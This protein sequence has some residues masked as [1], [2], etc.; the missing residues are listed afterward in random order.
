MIVD[1][2]KKAQHTSA[3]YDVCI[4]GSGPAGVTVAN[5]L[6]GTGLK[7]CVLESGTL[8]RKEYADKLRNVI[9]EGINIKDC[10]RERIIGGASSTW[11]GLSS[12]FDPIDFKKR[13]WVSGSGWPFSY[14][15]LLKYYDRASD[16]YNFPCVSSFSSSGSKKKNLEGLRLRWESIKEKI[17]IATIKPQRFGA[18]FLDIFTDGDIDLF[19]N[20]TVKILKKEKRQ[21]HEVVVSTSSR[22]ELAIK[23]KIFVL[24]AG[25]IENP[26]ILLHSNIGNENDQ[27]GRYFM[28]HPKGDC[29]VI[30]LSS[31]RNSLAKYFG[32][33]DKKYSRFVG[34]ALPSGVQEDRKILNSYVRLLPEYPWSGN[35]GVESL[36]WLFKLSKLSVRRILTSDHEGMIALR[37]YFET[38]DF[39]G[40]ADRRLSVHTLLRAFFQVLRHLPVISQYIYYRLN[41]RATPSL[42]KI[43]LRNFMEMAP[44]PEN[45][46]TLSD[47]N[48]AYGIPIPHVYHK[49]R[50]IEKRTMV[51]LHS[52]LAKE[53]ERIGVGRLTSNLE[54]GGF[55]RIIE[56]ASHHMGSTRMGINP[57]TSVVDV[58]CKVHTMDNIYVAGSSVFATSS[59]MNPTFTIVALAIRLADHIKEIQTI[60]KLRVR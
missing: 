50:E 6:R 32:Y 12:I 30:H 59:C 9:S 17:F 52:V 60:G 15:E 45:R 47:T 3:E 56:D 38:G 35:K 46:V 43:I 37:D 20:A 18:S 1:L 19:L 4:I 36:V 58:N 16:A 22:R 31:N 55:S 42:S 24:A 26:R 13:P 57:D 14:K 41:A 27:V 48:D 10:S 51:V 44:N 40:F 11:S 54:K 28:N 49:N 8:K 39:V 21:I 5:E 29:G 2:G 23:S 7:V 34:L 25:G 53:V 33:M